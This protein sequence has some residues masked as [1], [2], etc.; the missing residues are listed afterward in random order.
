[1]LMVRAIQFTFHCC[2]WVWNDEFERLNQ[3]WRQNRFALRG[4]DV[5]S[6]ESFLY[7]EHCRLCTNTTIAVIISEISFSDNSNK[8]NKLFLDNLSEIFSH[9]KVDITNQLVHFNAKEVESLREFLLENLCKTSVEKL[10]LE[11]EV[12]GKQHDLESVTLRKRYK[13]TGCH[14]DIYT[15]GISIENST[16][17][18]D[19]SKIIELSKKNKWTW[20]CTPSIKTNN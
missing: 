18:K 19:F 16:L 2:T 4:Q 12:F 14:D 8:I 20:K 6:V 5:K 17:H 3:S 10:Q 15:L 9:P 11:L 1:M 13:E 7:W